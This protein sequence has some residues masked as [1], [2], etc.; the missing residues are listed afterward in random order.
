MYFEE[1]Y[2]NYLKFAKKQQ[3]K[4]SFYTLV[5]NFDTRVLPYFKGMRL[6]EINRDTIIK[7]EDYILSLNF[8][9]SY[10]KGL[11]FFNQS[12]YILIKL[13]L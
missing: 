2:T 7:W 8:S 6:E 10:N 13:F 4:Q 3:K 12:K 1:I 9:N 11:Y 5:Y